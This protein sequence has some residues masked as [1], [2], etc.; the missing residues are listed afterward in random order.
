MCVSLQK[1]IMERKEQEENTSSETPSTLPNYTPALLNFSRLTPSQF[2]ISAQSFTPS[3]T[4][5]GE[6]SA[7]VT[8]DGCLPFWIT[9]TAAANF[10]HSQ[11]LQGEMHALAKTLH[12]FVSC[13]C[14]SLA[15][16][17]ILW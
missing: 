2:G 15:P 7:G 1:A 13:T 4:P 3:A 8:G 11:K 14:H 16:L 12:V 5:K 10:H 17:Q 9:D 6:T